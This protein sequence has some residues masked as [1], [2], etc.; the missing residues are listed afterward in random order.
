MR[1]VPTSGPYSKLIVSRDGSSDSRQPITSIEKKPG[2]QKRSYAVSLL[3]FLDCSKLFD[4][5]VFDFI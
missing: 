2:R 5:T 3:H 1:C 4:K